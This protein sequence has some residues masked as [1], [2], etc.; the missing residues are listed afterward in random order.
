MKKIPQ[1]VLQFFREQGCVVVSTID[2]KDRPHSACKGIVKINSGGRVYIVDL[3]RAVTYRNILR[4]SRVSITAFDE[5][6]FK[7]YCL[8]GKARIAAAGEL[9]GEIL[10]AWEDRINSRITRRL[11]RNIREVK[12]QSRHPEASLPKPTYMI[13][14]RVEEIVDLTPHHL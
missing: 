1:E 7:G 14:V 3:Y 6:R 4:N 2:S 11:I 13:I 8:K 10:K 5:H 12:G 9:K